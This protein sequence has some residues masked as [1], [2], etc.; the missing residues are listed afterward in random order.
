MLVPTKKDQKPEALRDGDNGLD[1]DKRWEI[2]SKLWK[3]TDR[4]VRGLIA[5]AQ[6]GQTDGYQMDG[7]VLKKLKYA[8]NSLSVNEHHCKSKVCEDED[9]KMLEIVK[10]NLRRI[11]LESR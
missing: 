1:C 8:M 5:H 2:L 10:R 3:E 4:H 11:S 7:K 6:G 9:G